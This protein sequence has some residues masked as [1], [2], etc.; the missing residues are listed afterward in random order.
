MSWFNVLKIV[1]DEYGML[2]SMPDYYK[3]TRELKMALRPKVKP[4]HNKDIMPNG[5]P[6]PGARRSYVRVNRK[7][8]MTLPNGFWFTV[9]GLNASTGE[10]YVYRFDMMDDDGDLRYLSVKGPG[11][12]HDRW[13]RVDNEEQLILDISKEIGRIHEKWEPPKADSR[14]IMDEVS[15]EHATEQADIDAHTEEEKETKPS[16]TTRWRDRLRRWRGKR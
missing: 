13:S 5:E 8:G 6:R 9:S 16:L 7:A 4:Y 14:E 15:R 11:V 3:F 1:E 12:F 10:R 2:L